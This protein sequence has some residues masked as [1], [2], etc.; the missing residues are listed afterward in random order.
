M[1]LC[2]C[3]NITNIYTV[4]AY[5]FTAPP[6]ILG[7]PV[8]KIVTINND[9][10]SVAFTCTANGSSSFS[11]ER[12]TGNIPSDAEGIDSN[13]LV[14]HNILPPDNGNYRCLARNGHGITHSSYAMLTVKGIYVHTINHCMYLPTLVYI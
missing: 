1:F 10:T 5:F 8:D 11:W 14:L 3:V 4:I 13:H 6:Q 9:S 7:H 2:M 12:D